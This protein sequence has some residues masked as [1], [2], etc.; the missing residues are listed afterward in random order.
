MSALLLLII[1]LCVLVYLAT[2]KLPRKIRI[3]ITAT[4]LAL[5]VVVPGALIL[6]AP[7]LV[8]CWAYYDQCTAT[9]ISG[10]SSADC[11]KRADSLGYLQEGGICLVRKE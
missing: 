8:S 4:V 6:F 1:I 9:R 5:L 7:Q 10:L 2:F 3:A 11:R